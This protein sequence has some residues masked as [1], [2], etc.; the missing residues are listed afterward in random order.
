MRGART[1]R[2]RGGGLEHDPAEQ[3]AD[4]ERNCN[5]LERPRRDIG[6]ELLA[7]AVRRFK[8]VVRY[9]VF[10]QRLGV[11]GHAAPSCDATGLNGRWRHAVPPYASDFMGDVAGALRTSPSIPKCEPWHGQ[12]QQR[13]SE[14]QC[15][16]QFTCEHVAET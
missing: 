15:T 6:L 16:T 5:G 7:K 3:Q 14:F 2:A 12:S 4:H 11:D 9:F 13:S 10:V 1:P 8:R